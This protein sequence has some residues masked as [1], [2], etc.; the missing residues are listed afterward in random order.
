MTFMDDVPT[1]LAWMEAHR[2]R[3]GVHTDAPALRS[4][5]RRV[6]V[7]MRFFDRG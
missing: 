3:N 5:L 7:Y 2:E 6:P 1:L 4:W